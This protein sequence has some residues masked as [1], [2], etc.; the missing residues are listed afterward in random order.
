MENRKGE[1]VYIINTLYEKMKDDKFVCC[2]VD[3]NFTKEGK[4]WKCNNCG[5]KFKAKRMEYCNDEILETVQT[6]AVLKNKIKGRKV[7]KVDDSHIGVLKHNEYS[8]LNIE[9]LE[10]VSEPIKVKNSVQSVLCYNN[11]LIATKFNGKLLIYTL[12]GER[13]LVKEIKRNINLIS[14]VGY[15]YWLG[16]ECNILN[17]YD[18]EFNVVEKVVDI[19]KIVQC[20]SWL[21]IIN[22]DINKGCD[23]FA[24]FFRYSKEGEINNSS[25]IV[26]YHRDKSSY[27]IINWSKLFTSIS[28]SFKKEIFFG[29]ETDGVLYKLSKEQQE[30][31]VLLAPV[32][33]LITDGGIFYVAHFSEKP[34]KIKL[35][36]NYIILYLY[37]IQI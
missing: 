11:Q 12:K 17:V 2:K 33:Q 7:N 19:G 28:Y 23:E 16:L 37:M 21:R 20:E 6:G 4:F 8:I 35:W 3:G 13:E 14:P 36:A 9:N 27:I 24:L 15:G 1:N 18:D 26:K 34:K 29:I 30:K 10:K 32:I 22:I 31:E 25:I 5:K